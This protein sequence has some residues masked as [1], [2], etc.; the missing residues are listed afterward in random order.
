MQSQPN[1]TSFLSSGSQQLQ[2]PQ[3]LEEASAA[4]SLR[5]YTPQ[6][7][8]QQRFCNGV[9]GSWRGAG[10]LSYLQKRTLPPPAGQD[11]PISATSTSL[12]LTSLAS[13]PVHLSSESLPFKGS[14][15]LL[16][17]IPTLQQPLP[18][19]SSPTPL[20]AHLTST[21]TTLRLPVP[22]TF[23]TRAFAHGLH[24]A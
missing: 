2:Q 22:A 13:P 3:W 17:I 9:E 8:E 7:L 11:A 15:G 1:L 4:W 10:A 16:R 20:Q 6:S 5:V 23:Y 24:S 21:E 19:L 12:S 14:L 18:S